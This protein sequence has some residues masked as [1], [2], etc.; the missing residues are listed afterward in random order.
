MAH[1]CCSPKKP[2][3]GRTINYPRIDL[4]CT[5]L[6]NIV[7]RKKQLLPL[8]TQL[9]QLRSSEAVKGGCRHQAC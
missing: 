8:V 5:T 7:S 1:C 4:A 3:P 6:K 9:I 2:R